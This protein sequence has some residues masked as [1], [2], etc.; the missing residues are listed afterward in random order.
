[1]GGDEAYRIRVGLFRVSYVIE[2]GKLVMLIVRVGHRKDV[3][4]S[5]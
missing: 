3:C 1:M 4:R 5:R 2:E